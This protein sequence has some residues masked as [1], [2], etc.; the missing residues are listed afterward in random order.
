MKD[1]RGGSEGHYEVLMEGRD[2]GWFCEGEGGWILMERM[3]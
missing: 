1:G 3:V 2:E